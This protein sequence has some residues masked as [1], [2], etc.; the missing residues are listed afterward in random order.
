MHYIL[1]FIKLYSNALKYG[2]DKDK[3]EFSVYGITIIIL[4]FGYAKDR[5]LY[6][7]LGF[8]V[9]MYVYVS[10]YCDRSSEMF[11]YYIDVWRKPTQNFKTV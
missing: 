10:K 6:F 2:L 8:A 9:C 1:R 3:N 4:L 11:S 5:F 7:L